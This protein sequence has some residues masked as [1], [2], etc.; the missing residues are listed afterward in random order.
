MPLDG[1]ASYSDIAKHVD[2]PEE[3]V[4][5][6]L[7]HA[8]TLRVFEETDPGKPLTTRVRHTARSAALAQN[9]GL[10]GLVANI[11]NDAGPPMAVLPYALDKFQ[12]GKKELVEDMNETAFVLWQSGELSK[13]YKTSWELLD[14]DGEGEKKGYRMKTFVKWMNYIKDIFQLEGLLNTAYDWKAA[15]DLKVV[16]VSALPPPSPCRRV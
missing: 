2:L 5:R 9:E 8:Y 15:G 1:D 4:H 10:S 7:E 14:E 13:G 3:V 6:L 12:R 11:M 16:D